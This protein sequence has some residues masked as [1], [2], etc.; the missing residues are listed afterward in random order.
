[1][2]FFSTF[3]G[4]PVSC[5]AGLAV[6]DVIEQ[7][8]LQANAL[9]VGN[10]LLDGMKSLMVSHPIIGDVRGVGL[11]L[12]V[13][14]VKDQRTLEP[15]PKQAAYVI[16]RLRNHGILAGTDGPYHN[17]IKLRPSM[18]FAQADAELFLDIFAKILDE[19]TNEPVGAANR[20]CMIFLR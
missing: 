7:E 11:F 16:N 1:M 12:G 6:L 5:A 4:N 13:E 9:L 2:E 8:G 17:V 10:L 19:V 14:L 20:N 15:A 3:G 18:I